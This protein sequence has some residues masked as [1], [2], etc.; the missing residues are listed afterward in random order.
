[1]IVGSIKENI[2]SE[3]SVD[4]GKFLKDKGINFLKIDVDGYEDEVMASIDEILKNS[5][6]M[7]ILLCTY[8]SDNDFK[9]YSRI[10]KGYKYKVSNSKGYMIF[11]WDKR[12][13]YPFLRRGVLRA[14]K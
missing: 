11:Y 12:L 4:G 7:K 14:E 3:K 5:S 10:L 1:M 2:D 6:K 8:H 9:K 13:S